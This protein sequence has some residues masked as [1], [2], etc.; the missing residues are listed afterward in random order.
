MASRWRW[1]IWA[2]PLGLVTLTFAL[3]WHLDP[4]FWR[5]PATLLQLAQAAAQRVEGAWR[6]PPR[7]DP[8]H[9]RLGRRRR[10]DDRV[11]SRSQS[12]VL[13]KRRKLHQLEAADLRE[14]QVEPRSTVRARIALQERREPHIAFDVLLSRE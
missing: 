3:T 8:D 14:V 7:R 4:D 5:S 13:E 9:R 1:L 6:L 12:F 11:A 2:V 10:S